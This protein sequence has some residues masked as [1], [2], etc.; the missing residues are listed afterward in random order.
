MSVQRALSAGRGDETDETD[1]T[2][3]P[4]L[5]GTWRPAAAAASEPSENICTPDAATHVSTLLV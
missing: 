4:E 1:E 3:V 5:A 2:P